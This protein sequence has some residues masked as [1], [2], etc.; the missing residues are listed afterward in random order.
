[1]KTKFE[2]ERIVKEFFNN[3]E[4][5]KRGGLLVLGYLV[6]II[7]FSLTMWLIVGISGFED[8]SAESQYGGVFEEYEMMYDS[9]DDYGTYDTN[10]TYGLPIINSADNLIPTIA[11]ISVMIIVSLGFF[12]YSWYVAGYTLSIQKE[13]TDN[14]NILLP[15]HDFSHFGYGLKGLFLGLGFGLYTFAIILLWGIIFGIPFAVSLTLELNILAVLVG[16]LAMII[17]FIVVFALGTFASP[18]MMYY[19]MVKNSIGEAL[20][21]RN[22]KSLVKKYWLSFLATYGVIFAITMVFSFA[23]IF[24]QLIPI[25]GSL[26]YMALTYAINILVAVIWGDQFHQIKALEEEK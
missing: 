3:K 14:G 4:N 12:A 21:L 17:L 26:L 15:K 1:M 23:G 24:L 5:L 2:L 22:W 16:I 25:L 18:A 10:D 19:F 13:I 11:T 7:A 8:Y 6:A 20:S 9:Y